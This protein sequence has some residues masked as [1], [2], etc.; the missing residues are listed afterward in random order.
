MKLKWCLRGDVT[1]PM[2]WMVMKGITVGL[3]IWL[4]QV[5]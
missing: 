3:I 2:D 5:K 4:K 1:N